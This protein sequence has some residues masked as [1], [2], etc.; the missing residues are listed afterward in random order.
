M[1]CTVYDKHGIE[2]E[3]WCVSAIIL[4]KMFFMEAACWVKQLWWLDGTQ[5]LL[6]ATAVSSKFNWGL[7]SLA[8]WMQKVNDS[9][10]VI[11]LENECVE[12]KWATVRTIEVLVPKCYFCTLK[13]KLTHFMKVYRFLTF[14]VKINT[15]S[16]W[17]TH[18]L[19]PCLNSHVFFNSLSVLKL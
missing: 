12:E 9:H 16:E 10:C 5:Y 17:C 3:K 6:S 19:S 2:I 4:G 14:K 8:M 13:R 1:C 7:H 11:R 18:G 15:I